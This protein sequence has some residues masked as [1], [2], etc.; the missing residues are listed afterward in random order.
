MKHLLTLLLLSPIIVFAQISE[1]FSDGNF[2]QNPSWLGNQNKFIVNDD[3]IL[4]L[5][6]SEAG[7]SMLSTDNN[8]ATN[9]EWRFWVKLSFSPS[10]NNNARVYLI[11]DNNDLSGSVDGYFVQLGESGSNDAIEL[12]KQSGNEIVSVCRGAEGLI[13]SSFEIGIKIIRDENSL[14]KIYADPNGGENYQLQAEA[15]DNT[16]EITSHFGVYCKYTS[17][18]S[19][20]FYFDNIYVGEIIVDNQPPVISS[21]DVRS[22]TSL[23]IYFDEVVEQSSAENALNYL[24]DN[25]I[26]NPETAQTNLSDARQV[27]LNFANKFNSGQENIITVTAIKDLSGNVMISQQLTFLYFEAEPYDILINEIM[28]DPSPVVDLPEYEYLELFNTLSHSVN[29]NGWKLLIGSS[30]KVF[31][32][33]TIESEGYLILAKESAAASF[34]PYGNFYG[35]GSFTLTNS[36]QDLVL[37]SKEGYEIS[38]VSYT[39]EWYNNYEKQ[40]GGWSLE[41]I[42]PENI[43]SGAEN[44]MAGYDPRGGSPGKVNSVDTDLHLLPKPIKFEMLDNRK[45]QL[46]FSQKM[47]S[48]SMI[49]N[50][51]FMVDNQVGEPTSIFF[52]GFKPQKAVLTFSDDFQMGTTYKMTLSSQIKNCRGDEM[53]KDTVLVFGLPEDPETMDIVINEV[54]FNPLG[55]GVD[56]VELFNA[57]FKVIDLGSMQIGSVRISPPNP[58]DTTFYSISEEQFLLVPGTYIC[59]TSSPIKVKEQYFTQNPNGFLKVDPF[60]ALNN[61]D[62]SVLLTTNGNIMIDAF[63]YTEEMQYPL[64]VYVDGV[65][66][67]RSGFLQATN[68][69]TNWHSAAESVGFATPAYQNS[70]FIGEHEIDET[71]VVEPEIFSPDNDGYNDLL[72]IKYQFEQPGFMMTID[73]YNSRGYPVRKLVNN[74]YLGVSGSVNWDGIQDDN[75]KAA[76]GIYVIFIQV[77]DLDGNV[78]QFK[79]PVVLASRL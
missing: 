24:V 4:Q 29:L 73:I 63:D 51:Y 68:D 34:E 43:C 62:G 69:K 67:E 40:D 58:P 26:G 23:T 7:L 28:A 30:E 64:L 9:C 70:Q 75:T 56:F 61:D 71:I 76:V 78:K 20:K 79:K 72:S 38:T 12:F 52:S 15:S 42:D 25:G 36:G 66:L 39:D 50:S 10:S 32:D 17:S 47:D 1:D 49:T 6:D 27:I 13:S 22:D 21:I 18:N 5:K 14:W 45:I 53:G 54:L 11:A 44:W 31:G 19:S 33:I 41:Q 3:F 35:F 65:S 57:S 60:P 8:I 77:F 74:Q 2:T 48:I 55:D 59:L 46:T 37:V 16:H